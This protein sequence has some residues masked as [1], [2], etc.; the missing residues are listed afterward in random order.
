M[1]HMNREENTKVKCYFCESEATK[2]YRPDMDL[3]GIPLCDGDECFLRLSILLETFRED[4]R[5]QMPKSK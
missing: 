1:E 5:N 3:R 2:A 4:A